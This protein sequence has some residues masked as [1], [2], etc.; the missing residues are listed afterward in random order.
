MYFSWV[1]KD[2]AHAAKVMND[3]AAVAVYWLGMLSRFPG[4]H[5]KKN[6][7]V[8]GCNASFDPS[9]QGILIMI[10]GVAL[11]PESSK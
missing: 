8:N 7:V 3:A 10:K 2:P 4:G 11:I 6:K 5:D 1:D 9:S